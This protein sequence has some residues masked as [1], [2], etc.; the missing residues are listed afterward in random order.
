MT[1]KVNVTFEN[2]YASELSP[3]EFITRL[4][5]RLEPDLKVLKL[6]VTQK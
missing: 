3:Q 4:F 1:L 5:K 2:E 6:T